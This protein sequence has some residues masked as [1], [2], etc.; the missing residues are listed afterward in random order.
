[1]GAQVASPF[2]ALLCTTHAWGGIEINTLRLG[3]Q[4]R[5]RGRRCVIVASDGSPLHRESVAAGCD[6]L[7][8]MHPAQYGDVR[9]A[10]RVRRALAEAGAAVLVANAT[11][12]LNLAVL[13]RGGSRASHRS[14]LRLVV[15]Q[16]MQIGVDK[17]D[18]LHRWHFARVDAWIAPL[19][20][21]ALQTRERTTM[22]ADRIHV[23]PFGIALE[24]FSAS[25]APSRRAARRALDLPIDVPLIGVIG[26]LDYGKGQEY[27]VQALSLLV[28]DGVDAHVLIVGEE[29]RGELQGYDAVLHSL[30][31]ERKL[32]D[33]VHFRVFTRDV[34]SVYRCLDVFALTSLAE[35]YGMVT[36][37]AMASALP[38]VATRSG[39]TP[40]I[41]RDGETGLLVPPADARALADALAR[42]LADPAYAADLADAARE[43]ALR[44]FS[45][46][47]ACDRYE[48]V[49]R[50]V[51]TRSS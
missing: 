29:T 15:M 33:R 22:T 20:S 13:A 34:T 2:I 12:D 47:V 19:P 28:H 30:V 43:D 31:A 39:G 40:D 9:N 51:V 24:R 42:L 8:L 16:H 25:D 6:V 46:E 27:L 26:R 3:V 14:V 32:H 10:R 5:E 23:I 50:S 4:L 36:I 18:L 17:R 48:A 49:F 37:E 41:I 7:P 38:V 45:R 1:M 35:T 44:R 11:R 21:L